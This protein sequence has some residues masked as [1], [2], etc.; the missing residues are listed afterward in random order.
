MSELTPVPKGMCPAF[1]QFM[2]AGSPRSDSGEILMLKDKEAPDPAA[3]LVAAAKACDVAMDTAA[4]H[5]VFRILPPAYRDSWAAAHMALAAA[6]AAYE[7]GG[8]T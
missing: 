8:V 1:Y 5:D 3:E 2:G 4:M 7:K 6:I